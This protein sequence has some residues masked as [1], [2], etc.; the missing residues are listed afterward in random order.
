MV[1]RKGDEMKQLSYIEI[2]R[3][4][5]KMIKNTMKEYT[6]NGMGYAAATGRLQVILAEA[7]MK[8]SYERPDLVNEMMDRF[9]SK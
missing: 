1:N 2:D 4:I 5:E 3:A 7:M 9:G 6:N 8:L